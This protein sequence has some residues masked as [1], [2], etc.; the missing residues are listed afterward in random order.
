MD[1]MGSSTPLWPAGHLPLKGGDRAVLRPWR[2][3]EAAG[4]G[5]QMTRLISPLEGEMAGRPE[6][7]AFLQISRIL[8]GATCP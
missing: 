8:A 2:L 6:G 5:E 4:S 7:G 1:A 3:P